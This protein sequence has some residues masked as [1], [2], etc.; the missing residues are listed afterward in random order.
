[1]HLRFLYIVAV[2]LAFM[3]C[4]EKPNTS[5]VNP[6]TTSLISVVPTPIAPAP[7]NIDALVKQYGEPVQLGGEKSDRYVLV[8]VSYDSNDD[9]QGQPEEPALANWKVTVSGS[10]AQNRT[11]STWFSSIGTTNSSGGFLLQLPI[12]LNRD[13]LFTLEQQNS[14]GGLV[15]WSALDLSVPE[16]PNTHVQEVFLTAGCRAAKTGLV[17][18]YPKGAS[19]A[20]IWPC[21]RK[22]RQTQSVS[23]TW[24][25]LGD[26]IQSGLTGKYGGNTFIQAFRVA[27]DGSPLLAIA[28]PFSDVVYS[29]TRFWK[30]QGTWT[31]A[32]PNVT[33]SDNSVLPTVR[34]DPSGRFLKS[35]WLEESRSYAINTTQAQVWTGNIPLA[36]NNGKWFGLDLKGNPIRQNQLDSS[37][38][39][40]KWN[41]SKWVTV[42]QHSE[43]ASF[44]VTEAGQIYADSTAG[45]N[46]LRDGTW[47]HVADALQLPPRLSKDF[48]RLAASASADLLLDCTVR[49]RPTY[50]IQETKGFS[51]RAL[52][53]Y[54]QGVWEPLLFERNSTLFG[55]GFDTQQRAVSAVIEGNQLFVNRWNTDHWEHVGSALNDAS[56]VTPRGYQ[57]IRFSNGPDGILFVAWVGLKPPAQNVYVSQLK[58]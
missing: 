35:T 20:A 13:L 11:D 39:L 22:A 30:W 44:G 48:C 24:R 46:F 5:E 53:L 38:A 4:T 43:P 26:G 29:I 42:T 45:I 52:Y 57:N 17:V 47:I 1:M 41:G 23:G 28:S 40:E 18:P 32:L 50:E 27:P 58:E 49:F 16:N 54:H 9:L 36:Q 19:E 25:S 33:G 51:A 3:G 15:T 56:S 8:K 6:S 21:R 12:D 37:S 7:F 14:A 2:G 55:I 34:I 10:R 31:S